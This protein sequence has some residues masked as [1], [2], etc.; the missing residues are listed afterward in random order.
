MHMLC[1]G[2]IAH[3]IGPGV[4]RRRESAYCQKK[5][6]P[7][8]CGQ[9]NESAIKEAIHRAVWPD[10]APSS[11]HLEREQKLGDLWAGDAPSG[12]F[13]SLKLNVQDD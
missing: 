4:G 11:I 1:T 3:L 2:R 7:Q 5:L 12:H 6:M 9:I 8:V 10:A 13:R